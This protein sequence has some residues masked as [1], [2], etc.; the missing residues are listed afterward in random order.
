MQKALALLLGLI[1]TFQ[2]FSQESTTKKISLDDIFNSRQFH[3]KSVRGIASM[4]DGNH[5]CQ[6]NSRG[7]VESSYKTGE[8]TRVI[9]DAS[10]LYL[11]DST[12]IKINSYRF[13]NSETQVLISTN[14]ESI[15]RHSTKSDYYI[16]DINSKNLKSLSANGKQSLAEFSPDGTKVAFVRENNLF[17]VD[18]INGDETQ[19]TSDG[20]AEAIL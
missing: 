14:T 2:A 7:I 19:F 18:L 9:V 11:E 8:E 16:Y 15:Y 4:N 5:Y 10:Q 6:L 17:L 20:K 13:N 1:L 3:P 12:L